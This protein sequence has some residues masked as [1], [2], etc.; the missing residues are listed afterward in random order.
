MAQSGLIELQTW[1]P[2]IVA[3]QQCRNPR[4]KIYGLIG[5]DYSNLEGL[6]PR[7]Q[8]PAQHNES[9]Y[10]ETRYA[11]D[12]PPIQRS[13]SPSKRRPDVTFS[14]EELPIDFVDYRKP[15]ETVFRDFARLMVESR[16]S[17]EFL[18]LYEHD[19]T[20]WFPKFLSPVSMRSPGLTNLCVRNRGQ[21]AASAE[22]LYVPLPTTDERGLVVQGRTVANVAKD[23]AEMPNS[24]I[25]EFYYN[26]AEVLN[27]QDLCHRC[28]VHVTP[29]YGKSA[30][31]DW[32]AAF[33]KDMIDTIFCHESDFDGTAPVSL[34]GRST[35]EVY[36]IIYALFGLTDKLGL[37]NEEGIALKDHERQV[38]RMELS[39]KSLHFF[40]RRL[41][42]LDSGHLALVQKGVREGDRVAILH[43]LNVPCVIRNVEDG[44]KWRWLGDAF[45]LG[46]MRGEEVFW[47]EDDAVTFTLV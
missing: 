12:S 44:K 23:I 11:R 37:E 43:G 20:V 25:K 45:I 35:A 7:D 46:M 4:D 21:F 3:T 9:G 6:V 39:N 38:L 5:L 1:L 2:L 41:V 42:L 30:E 33:T 34:D 22:R 29:T 26:P 10:I 40:G 15:I 13:S 17:L 31:D 36:T 14:I 8:P 18:T 24:K 19:T 32:V 27:V 16:R 47:E 28:W